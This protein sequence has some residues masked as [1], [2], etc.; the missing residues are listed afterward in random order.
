VNVSFLTG[1]RIT[2]IVTAL[3]SSIFARGQA[4]QTVSKSDSLAVALYM[5]TEHFQVGQTA[6]A[7]LTVY[8]MSDQPVIFSDF[9][10]CVYVYGKDGE[11]P[12]TLFQRQLTGRLRPGE[13]P[14]SYTL[15]VSI[16][17]LLW[18]AGG[19]WDY[20]D[21]KFDLSY[22]YDLT[23]PGRYTAYAEVMDPSS[24]RLLRSKTRTFDMTAPAERDRSQPEKSRF[25]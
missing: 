16:S 13:S 17:P 15:N 4:T 1:L 9:M 22:L 21:R 6:W 18:P 2:F 10:C 24:N 25:R 12:T 5:P 20:A 11:A 8:N 23:A 3:L 14:L 7:I 19:A